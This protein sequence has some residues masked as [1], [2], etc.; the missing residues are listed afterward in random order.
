MA[1]LTNMWNERFAK[2]CSKASIQNN[3]IYYGVVQ[4]FSDKVVVESY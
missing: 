3:E 4:L 2:F 1:I